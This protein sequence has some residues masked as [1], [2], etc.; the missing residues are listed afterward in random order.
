MVVVVNGRR[1]DG[2]LSFVYILWALLLDQV[3]RSYSAFVAVAHLVM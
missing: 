1:M 2:F 3:G